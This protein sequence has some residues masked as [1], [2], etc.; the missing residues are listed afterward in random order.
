V[1]QEGIKSHTQVSQ[2]HPLHPGS[3]DSLHPEQLVPQSSQ[4][5]AQASSQ[6]ISQ[7]K[8]LLSHTHDSQ[9]QEWQPGNS[10]A[11]LHPEQLCP[12][13]SHRVTQF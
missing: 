13:P 1:Q 3:G 8:E 6:P 10:G 9:E 11:A 4:A 12:Q 2:G 5:E 7:Q